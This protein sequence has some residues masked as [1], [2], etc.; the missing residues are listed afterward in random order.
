MKE[1]G[2]LRSELKEIMKSDVRSELGRFFLYFSCL[3]GSRAASGVFV[4]WENSKGNG[5]LG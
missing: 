5:E 3:A 4:F 1:F 2:R